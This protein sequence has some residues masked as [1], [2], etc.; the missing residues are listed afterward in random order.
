MLS[1]KDLAG[2]TNR[3][4]VPTVVQ[5]I[6]DGKESL[7]PDVHYAL[8]ETL[9]D[10]NPDS[11]LLCIALAAHKIAARYQGLNANLVV[12]K[13]ECER[14]IHEYAPL[15]LSNARD[16]AVDEHKVLQTLVHLPEDL[17]SLVELLNISMA[18]LQMRCMDAAELSNILMVQAEAQVLI[19]ESFVS[20]MDDG[21]EDS[22]ISAAND[23]PDVSTICGISA[24]D[25][26]IPFPGVQV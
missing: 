5:D 20:L 12:L 26:V 19:A 25:N 21:A 6:L 10:H 23:L 18:F 16:H 22:E 9:S 14:I 17:E 13:M 7:S 2:L 3:L 15:W 4:Q 11:A 24:G 8:H 1:E